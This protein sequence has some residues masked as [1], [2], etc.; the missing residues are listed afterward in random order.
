MFILD[1]VDQ[2]DC[3]T[4]TERSQHIRAIILSNAGCPFARKLSVVP[5]RGLLSLAEKYNYGIP[6]IKKAIMRDEWC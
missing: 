6:A 1:R 3:K 4:R 5:D 2:L